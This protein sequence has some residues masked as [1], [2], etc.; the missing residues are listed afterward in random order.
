MRRAGLS[1]TRW[2]SV[3]RFLGFECWLLAIQNPD[4]SEIL[5]F[6]CWQCVSQ[7]KPINRSS[8]EEEMKV[9]V[10]GNGWFSPQ[11]PPSRPFISEGTIPALP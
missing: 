5:Y 11:T 4:Q 10:S 8:E 1:K 9:C 6:L 2:V 7:P 3:Y